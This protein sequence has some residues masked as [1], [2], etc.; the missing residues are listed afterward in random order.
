MPRFFSCLITLLCFSPLTSE[1]QIFDVTSYGA[2]G[3]DTNNDYG[4]IKL[5]IEAA[6]TST[7]T[8]STILF[9]AGTYYISKSIKIRSNVANVAADVIETE[10]Y[11]LLEPGR[12]LR[13][14]GANRNQTTIKVM[15]D[16]HAANPM[17]VF[18]GVEE[19]SVED[20]TLD[21]QVRSFG[22]DWS[23][24][25]AQCGVLLFG[26][27][28][29]D[30]DRVGFRDM[31]RNHHPLD[32]PDPTFIGPIP[33]YA[34]KPLP[35]GSHVVIASV[36]SDELN[37]G[38]L[39]DH[40]KKGLLKTTLPSGDTV[41]ASPGL[42][43]DCKGN[44]ISYCVFE[45][46][47]ATG[48]PIPCA[49]FAIRMITNWRSPK[50]HVAGEEQHVALSAHVKDNKIYNCDFDGGFY[51]NAVEL[52]GHGTI[53]NKV[54]LNDAYDCIQTALEADKAASYNEFKRNKIH[55]MHP[56]DPHTQYL[57][58]I[59]GSDLGDDSTPDLGTWVFAMRMQGYRPF[60]ANDIHPER[61]AVGNV[62]FE[63]K[64]Y[65]VNGN[66]RGT[67]AFLLSRTV[68]ATLEG[69]EVFNVPTWT[70]YSHFSGV[71]LGSDDPGAAIKLK[72]WVDNTVLTGNFFPESIDACDYV[73]LASFP[74]A[75]P[76]PIRIQNLPVEA[77]VV[78]PSGVT[79]GGTPD[80]HTDV[81][82]EVYSEF[83]PRGRALLREFKL[84]YPAAP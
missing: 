69:N 36:D 82:I 22:I 21:G 8:E 27:S 18:E 2:N 64:I 14:I 9:P 49:N 7:H 23:G 25:H 62:F 67:G 40:A 6:T 31:G 26:C 56:R 32:I 5:A 77:D 44:Q 66:T 81:T 33:Q 11:G 24:K 79:A 57:R 45:D 17:F 50:F 80:V 48:D 59:Y 28:D 13:F 61:S 1:A 72:Y 29:C 35:G 34:A 55:R 51:W 70:P 42:G 65:E 76:A 53:N 83:E 58:K 15:V 39:P 71:Y 75:R 73:Q 30:L 54:T 60:G 46:R 10:E 52:A 41:I 20:L 47:N 19:C 37:A 4:A 3:Q 43:L 74:K 38:F 16:E 68:D 78:D 84:D 12:S 63:N